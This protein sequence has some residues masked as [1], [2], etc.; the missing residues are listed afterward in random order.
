MKQVPR[1]RSTVSSSGCNRRRGIDRGGSQRAFPTK[2]SGTNAAPF[3][4][5]RDKGV[6]L[7]QRTTRVNVSVLV[8]VFVKTRGIPDASGVAFVNGYTVGGSTGRSLD[9]QR[10]EQLQSFLSTRRRKSVAAP[11]SCGMSTPP[12]STPARPGGPSPYRTG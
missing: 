5:G 7:P 4:R 6:I 11:A 10:A 8:A 3:R 12:D 2:L 1:E 9:E